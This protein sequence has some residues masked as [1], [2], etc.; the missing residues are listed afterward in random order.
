MLST[1]PSHALADAVRPQVGKYVNTSSI[2]IVG[3]VGD[4]S[5][6]P[7]ATAYFCN[8]RLKLADATL[9]DRHEALP[10]GV[11]AGVGWRT[12]GGMTMG[13]EPYAS[14]VPTYWRGPT[15]TTWAG[16]NMWWI[17]YEADNSRGL[18]QGQ[19]EIAG[20]ELWLLTKANTW[21]LVECGDKPAGGGVYSEDAITV[22]IGADFR[23]RDGGQSYL[24]LPGGGCAVHGWL[25]QVD[26]QSLVYPAD[27]NAIYAS[28]KHRRTPAKN[29]ASTM[30]IVQCGVDYT[31]FVGAT[32][33][34][35]SGGFG[36]WPGAGSGQFCICTEDWR[37]SHVLLRK[38][39]VSMQG[40]M[41]IDP[42]QFV[43]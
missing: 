22:K 1:A 35:D 39:G 6:L 23:L 42:P 27:I 32:V 37:Y 13:C 33:A 41:E 14:A 9:T 21:V 20:L 3:E 5:S 40:I 7:G 10:H 18:P 34:L 28:V 16:I 19:I 11:S 43:Y 36:Y 30:Y 2:I 15:Y 26:I 38:A 31:P 12:R 29:N 25:Q 17:A 4:Y 24:A 8:S